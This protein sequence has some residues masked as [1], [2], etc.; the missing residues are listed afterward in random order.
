MQKELLHNIASD[1][2]R[3]N[4]RM[5]HFTYVFSNLRGRSPARTRAAKSLSWQKAIWTITWKHISMIKLSSAHSWDAAN[6][7]VGNRG[8]KYTWRRILV[9]KSIYAQ[10]LP[11][12]ERFTRKEIW[13]PTWEFTR[14]KGR[15][16]ATSP[17]ASNR[18]QPKAIWMITLRSIR[19][20]KSAL[21]RAIKAVI[22]WTATRIPAQKRVN[23]QDYL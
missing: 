22:S 10:S 14:E 4:P 1:I 23:H 20:E 7:I 8:L 21:L 3:E 15:T 11:V 2:A 17:G 12:S 18:S 13:K 9:R 6:P 5:L 16:T 19:R